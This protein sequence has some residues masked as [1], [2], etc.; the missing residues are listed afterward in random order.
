MRLQ[1]RIRPLHTRRQ[2]HAD[3]CCHP[4][5]YSHQNSRSPLVVLI[6][7][8]H[9]HRFMI[10]MTV[11]LAEPS[12]ASETDCGSEGRRLL[13]LMDLLQRPRNQRQT[14]RVEHPV[15]N[16]R[17]PDGAMQHHDVPQAESK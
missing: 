17:R 6:P 15:R 12:T 16:H 13:D 5:R 2:K 9:C 10:N 4:G 3:I 7:A 1:A 8:L 14:C 11:M